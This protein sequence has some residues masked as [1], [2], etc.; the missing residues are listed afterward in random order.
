VLLDEPFSSLDAALRLST[1]RAVARAL[2]A[3][4]ATAILV[5]HD[6]NEALS[7]APLRC[8]IDGR[9][10]PRLCRGQIA[11]ASSVNAAATRTAG[12]AS[13]PSS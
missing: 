6:Q 11:R 4:H 9:V 13:I 10:E 12:A 5:T 8:R 7:L 2:H 3:A 1:G